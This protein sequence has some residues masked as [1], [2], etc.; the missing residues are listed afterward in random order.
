MMNIAANFLPIAR[1]ALSG[2]SR[3]SLRALIALLLVLPMQPGY[4][5]EGSDLRILGDVPQMIEVSEEVSEADVDTATQFVFSVNQASAPSVDV[6]SRAQVAIFFQSDY[7]STSEVALTWTGTVNACSAGTTTSTY[8]NAMLKRIKFFR[9]MAG[10][11][12]TLVFSDTLNN[13]AQK[14]ALMMSANTALSHTPPASWACY[15]SEGAQAA[16]KS[17][18]ALGYA[19]IYAIDGYMQDPGTGNGAVGH[20]R[21]LLYPQTTSMG[22]GDVPD[23]NTQRPAN[24]LVVI[25]GQYGTARPPTR[26]GFVA[27]PPSGFVP[28]QVTYARW[29]FSYPG[30][31]FSS[32]TVSIVSEG[33]SIPVQKESVAN[34]YGENTLAWT[35]NGMNTY[36]DW[37]PPSHDTP[38]EVQINN[39]QLSGQSQSFAYT[40]TVFD[41]ANAAPTGITWTPVAASENAVTATVYGG[42]DT[43]DLDATDMHTY[44]LV[45]GA[46]D[47]DNSRFS[48]NKDKLVGAGPLDYETKSTYSVRVQ[49]DDGHGGRFAKAISVTVSDLNEAPVD[50]YL[51]Q[52]ELR[53]TM[54]IGTNIGNLQAVDQDAG[55]SATFS[56]IDG[57]GSTDNALFKIQGNTLVLNT[58]LQAPIKPF[59]HVWVQATDS[60]GNVFS[61]EL[62]VVGQPFKMFVPLVKR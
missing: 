61:K 37:S 58:D 35:V 38:Y 21:W 60:A 56:L 19:G 12:T 48:V 18:L 25:N 43:T 6:Q 5:H 2:L 31:D 22:T 3:Q 32:A 23:S 49:T 27:W 39:V 62:W 59:Y 40:V 11:P 52:S 44:T 55:D 14:A 46:G 24:A 4:A 57:P 10:V 53:D 7:E 34:G 26:D 17:N 30:A 42:L 13:M 16:G 9:A 47:T 50:V 15:S 45:A 33:Q 51:A 8:R 41:P 28:Y 36:A 20:R 54:S 1:H 29:S